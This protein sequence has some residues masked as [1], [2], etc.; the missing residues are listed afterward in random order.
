MNEEEKYGKPV[1][2]HT[3]PK[4]GIS[5]S[6]LVTV[7]LMAVVIFVAIVHYGQK[8]GTSVGAGIE[9]KAPAKGSPIGSVAE[10]N[11]P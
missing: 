7:G 4:R 2:R 3:P 1:D 5:F 10:T 8:K 9:S 6:Y 11:A